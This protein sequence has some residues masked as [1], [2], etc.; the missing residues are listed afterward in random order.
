[1]AIL[2][3]RSRKWRRRVFQLEIP[4]DMESCVRPQVLQKLALFC[5]T[6][7]DSQRF[8]A[9]NIVS[10]KLSEIFAVSKSVLVRVS[11]C[12]PLVEPSGSLRSTLRDGSLI[13]DFVA[14]GL[15][16]FAYFA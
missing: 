10:V 5:L 3:W 13:M 1:V 12:A 7:V 2:C 6:S 11:I 9:T 16:T 15:P 4:A 14:S 8:E